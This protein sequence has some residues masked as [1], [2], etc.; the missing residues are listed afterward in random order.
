MIEIAQIREVSEDDAAALVRLTTV[1]IGNVSDGT[2]EKINE[3]LKDRNV[4]L[5]AAKD[6]GAIIGIASLYLFPKI[7]RITARLEDVVVDEK[8]RGQGIGEK[9]TR[10]IIERARREG[11]SSIY[12]TS[13]E[14]RVA[15]HRLYEKVGFKKHET[16]TF[17]MSLG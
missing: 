8:C 2:S 3:M 9:L 12:L 15:A 4:F 13:Q 11:A 7:G 16:T 17:K 5:Y 14:T 1:L 10:T 6:D